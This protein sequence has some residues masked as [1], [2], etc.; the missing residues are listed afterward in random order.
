MKTR[1]LGFIILFFSGIANGQRIQTIV[2]KQPVVIGNA[3]QIQYVI[4][5]PTELTNISSPSYQDLKIVSGPNR[6]KGNAAINGKTQAIENITYT[7]VPLKTG[8][9]KVNGIS[10]VFKNGEEKSNDATVIIIS[11]PKASF[12]SSS[13]YTDVNLYAPSSKA[14]L[15]K[16]IAE[17]LFVKT[18]VDRKTCLLGEPIVA[19]FKLYSRLQSTSEVIN[20]PSLYGF[21]VMD[22]INIYEAHQSVETINGK[23]FNTS[24]LR[25]LQLYPE[26]TGK[27]TIDPMQLQNEI[28]FDDSVNGKKMEVQKS[29][30]SNSVEIDVKPL[31]GKQPED[32][33]GAVGNFNINAVLE[34]NKIAT[35]QQ[36]KLIVTVSGK[37]NF[38]QFAA[39]IVHFPK[40]FDL[41]DPVISDTLDKTIAPTE[42][43]RE[44]IFAFNTDSVG[45]FTLPPVTFNFFDAKTSS[46]RTVHSDSLQLEVS[47]ASQNINNNKREITEGQTRKLWLITLLVLIAAMLF[48]G[49]RLLQKKPSKESSVLIDSS[50]TYI[51]KFNEINFQQS[52]KQVCFEIQKLLSDLIKNSSLTKTQEQEAKSIQSECQLMIYSDV[53]AEEK[54]EEL[55]NRTLNLLR[56]TEQ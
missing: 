32:F 37:G 44:Y 23:I 9:I 43:K 2:P 34:K 1:L 48:I 39:P 5:D 36:G 16:L 27:L 47:A 45:S 33:S 11:P 24:V 13:S 8:N 7:V 50:K 46:Y 42:G 53:S 14:D 35:N 12:N 15:D 54:T 40:A 3:F 52:Q 26:Q 25:K 19:T 56:Q 4:T 51:Q 41:F 49:K 10:A 55:K 21:S 22:M 17:N 28:E 30:A 20:A 31:P 38:L 18:E 6:F 29:L